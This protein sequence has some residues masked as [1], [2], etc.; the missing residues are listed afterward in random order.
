MPSTPKNQRPN[1]DDRADSS[2]DDEDYVPKGVEE[3]E[4]VDDYNAKIGEDELETIGVTAATGGAG[5]SKGIQLRSRVVGGDAPFALDEGTPAV[6][7]EEDLKRKEE[8]R[9]EMEA[10][11]AQMIAEDEDG[12]SSGAVSAN[13]KEQGSSSHCGEV[14]K[15]VAASGG[16]GAAKEKAGGE[17]RFVSILLYISM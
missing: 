11:F 7:S 4:D 6:L 13:G 8:K 9:R 2:S 14:K 5:G 1:D 3:E 10:F 12:D 16:E 15:A 17:D